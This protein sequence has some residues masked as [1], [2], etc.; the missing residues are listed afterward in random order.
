VSSASGTAAAP[1]A[2]PEKAS[3]LD[4]TVP[5][6]LKAG[7][8]FVAST[9]SGSRVR[10]LVPEGA[11]ACMKVRINVPAE[12]LKR[13]RRLDMV[14]SP[15]EWRQSVYEGET[16]VEG[17]L[18]KKSGA[19]KTRRW[20]TRF[21]SIQGHY[22]KY[23]SDDRM[24]ATKGVLDLDQLAECHV[25]ADR[26]SGLLIVI[27]LLTRD[28]ALQLRAQSSVEASRWATTLSAF[29]KSPQG[30]GEGGEKEEEEEEEEEEGASVAPL[31]VA[32][33]AKAAKAA[34]AAKA[35]KAAAKGG[36]DDAAAADEEAEDER[37][38]GAAEQ[39]EES[40]A[41][42]P[43]AAGTGEE[44]KEEEEEAAGQQAVPQHRGEGAPPNVSALQSALRRVLEEAELREPFLPQAATAPSP[45]KKRKRRSSFVKGKKNLRAVRRRRLSAASPPPLRRSC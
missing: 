43:A 38:E 44:E 9:P 40:A 12:A 10:V 41:A 37:K 16:A 30:V 45:E 33:A 36:E 17:A 32:H 4:V 19:G 22:L 14:K 20:V 7:D 25:E 39:G 28:E 21:F 31:R 29:I 2:A 35:A 23:F 6:G 3:F 1:P 34:A 24:V 13:R 8:H 26:K 15:K 18:Q 11:G 42:D 5:A 27:L